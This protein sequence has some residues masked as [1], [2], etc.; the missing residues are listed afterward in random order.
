MNS[1]LKL[2]FFKSLGFPSKESGMEFIKQ[3]PK[4][5][6][7]IDQKVDEIEESRYQLIESIKEKIFPKFEYE[8]DIFI[9]QVNSKR[10]EKLAIK[11]DL[12]KQALKGELREEL[13]QEIKQEDQI[14]KQNKM[15]KKYPKAYLLNDEKLIEQLKNVEKLFSS[16]INKIDNDTIKE[17]NILI[18]EKQKAAVEKAFEILKKVMVVMEKLNN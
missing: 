10:T 5:K 8:K 4:L 11:K 12:Q 7:S 14:E 13:L 16:V 18:V 1:L 6:L 3:Q 17:D 2:E 9:I 15:K